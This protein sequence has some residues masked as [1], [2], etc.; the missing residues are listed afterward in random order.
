MSSFGGS[1]LLLP[2]ALAAEAQHNVAYDAVPRTEVGDLQG[3][4]KCPLPEACTQQL[5]DVVLAN[6]TGVRS[7]DVRDTR[8]LQHDQQQEGRAVIQRIARVAVGLHRGDHVVA[9]VHLQLRFAEVHI[10]RRRAGEQ[11]FQQCIQTMHCVGIGHIG[12]LG[13]FVLQVRRHGGIHD[14]ILQHDAV[15]LERTRQRADILNEAVGAGAVPKE[16]TNATEPTQAQHGTLRSTVGVLGDHRAGEEAVQLYQLGGD[17]EISLRHLPH[18]E[19]VADER[20]DSG[21][22]VQLGE[23]CC[24]AKH[25]GLLGEAHGIVEASAGE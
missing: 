25:A 4:K 24:Q 7:V 14:G 1:F 12:T 9:D 3:H 11:Q 15:V 17:G 18:G 2:V 5:E 13:I 8:A 21:I 22:A 20:R 19:L 6:D 10:R 16:H 23:Q